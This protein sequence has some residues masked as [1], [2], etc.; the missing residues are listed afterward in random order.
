MKLY[1]SQAIHS[2]KKKKKLETQQNTKN[3]STK[4]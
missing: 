3:H 2:F 1:Q 4:N